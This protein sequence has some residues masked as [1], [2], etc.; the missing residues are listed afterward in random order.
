M[1][2]VMVRHFVSNDHRNL[3]IRCAAL[4]K[5]AG[6]VDITSGASESVDMFHPWNLN[7]K[8]FGFR[9]ALLEFLFHATDTVK[10]PR[11]CLEG[12]SL[13]H[14]LVDPLTERGSAF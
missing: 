14:L 3:R 8:P 2:E 6:D 11:F 13:V 10:R 1:V 7:E 4:E 5:P 12:N 9:P